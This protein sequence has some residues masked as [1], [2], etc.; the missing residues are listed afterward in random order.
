MLLRLLGLLLLVLPFPAAAQDLAGSWALRI[1]GTTIFRFDLQPDGE[2]WKGSWSKPRS[3]ASDGDSFARLSGPPVEIA[4]GEGRAMGEW[5]ELTFPDPRPGAVP[6]IFRFRLLDKDRVEM[7][8]AETGLAPY[9]LVRVASGA[10]LGPWEAG[11][12]YRRPGAPI[13]RTP[14]A[15][16]QTA[17]GS[18]SGSTWSLPAPPAPQQPPVMLGR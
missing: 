7:I 17:P 18:R 16:A 11:K 4:A 3:F 2:S 1:E 13:A 12:V 15:P 14:A 5:A 9:E 10:Q 6:D 8:Y